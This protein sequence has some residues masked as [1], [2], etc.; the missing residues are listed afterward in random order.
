MELFFAAER[1]KGKS[2]CKVSV[3][4]PNYNGK[5]Y[6]KPCLDAMGRQSF[7]DFEVILVDNGSQDGS[8]EYTK[9]AYPWVR[10]IALK[11]N[12]GFCGAVNEGIRKSSSPYVLLLNNDTIA[13]KDFVEELVSAIEKRPKAFSC[14]AKLLEMQQPERADDAGNY[15]CALGWAF[16]EGK[17]RP[18]SRYTQ[19]KK[20]FASCAGAAIYRRELLQKTG[21]F[22]EEHFAYLEDIDIGYRGR[23]LGYE[24]W[25]C[26]KARVLHAGSGTT[27]SRYNLFKVRYSS[28]NNVYL[29]YKNMPLLQILWNFPL[30]FF[31]FGVKLLF[32][33]VKGFGKEYGAGLKN[34]IT[35]SMKQKEKKF[36]GGSIKVYLAIQIELYKNLGKLFIK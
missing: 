23:L 3:I 18:E 28:R 5:K 24:N 35:L 11:E 29:I 19:E 1:L 16:A 6:L 7:R 33:T 17:G 25:F 13:E 22:D 30:F 20:I 14:Q 27:G 15:Y 2:M 4:I 8:Q 12:T 9:T 36:Q 26:P 10:L 32:F 31:G 34:G 21:L